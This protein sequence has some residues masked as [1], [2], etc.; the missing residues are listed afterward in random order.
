MYQGGATAPYSGKPCFSGG[1]FDDCSRMQSIFASSRDGV[2][3]IGI[4][5]SQS[6]GLAKGPVEG[7]SF[8]YQHLRDENFQTPHLQVYH[9]LLEIYLL[10]KNCYLLQKH[11]EHLFHVKFTYTI[12][13][14]HSSL[15]S[16]VI[17][18]VSLLLY[19]H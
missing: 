7:N 11:V 4:R 3:I 5:N 18:S 6:L 2:L 19:V 8:N 15:R 16:H 10:I 9:S 1:S 17:T 13:N 12:R 14:I